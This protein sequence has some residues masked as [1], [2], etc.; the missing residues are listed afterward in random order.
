MFSCETR[1]PSP[2]PVISSG[3][4]SAQPES[5]RGTI[6]MISSHP[7]RAERESDQ[8][9]VARA[10][11]ARPPSGEQRDAEHAERE[12]RQGQ[13]GLHRVVLERHLQEDRERDHRAA[14]RDV[15]QQLPRDPGR[16][17]RE[18]E[19]AGIEQGQLPLPLA[20]HEPVGQ[21]ASAT[22]PTAISRP[23]NSPPSC[24]TRMP[25]TR[26]PMPSTE[27]I[28]PTKSTCRGPV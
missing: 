15:L 26:P 23:T 28:A 3:T 14:E 21:S 11:L 24:Q 22:A 19:Q 10:P 1:R 7:D 25:S 8:D 13:A 27:R 2:E 20:P 6:G 9:D 5:V 4:T 12:R 18:R 16:E 17:V